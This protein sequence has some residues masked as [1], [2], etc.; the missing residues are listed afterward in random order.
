MSKAA[1]TSFPT[2][3]LEDSQQHQENVDAQIKKRWADV[4]AEKG[5][6]ALYEQKKDEEIYQEFRNLHF[7]RLNIWYRDPNASP[8][9]CQKDYKVTQS[10]LNQGYYR[11]VNNI[12]FDYNH[13]DD[14]YNASTILINDQHFIA[15][16]E[17]N[18]KILSN[19]FTLLINHRASIL[20]RLNPR[21]EYTDD[22]S[23]TYWDN[24]L[25]SDSSMLKMDAV[26]WGFDTKPIY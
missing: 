3:P 7:L 14:H 2:L 5:N 16:Q 10:L 25:S 11:K 20:V 9:I 17:P 1:L 4:I 21:V 22:Q 24:R 26:F 8:R 12:A 23:I 13:T 6:F 18:L 19:F 15:L